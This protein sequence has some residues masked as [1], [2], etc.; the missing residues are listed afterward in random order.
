MSRRP[1][2]ADAP[3]PAMALLLQGGRHGRGAGDLRR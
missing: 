3:N 2:K 1:N